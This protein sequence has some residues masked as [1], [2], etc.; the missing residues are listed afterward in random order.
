[1]AQ[2][3]APFGVP[4]GAKGKAKGGI[5]EEDRSRDW[6]CSKCRERNFA[7]RGECFKCRSVKPKD[8]DCTAPPRP[9]VPQSGTTL[10]GMVKSYNKKGFG[11]IMVLGM[12]ECQDIYYTRENLSPRLQTRDIPG[13]H[14]TFEIHR[15][16]DGKLVA[17]NIR[18]IGSDRD[19]T[20]APPVAPVPGKAMGK[21]FGNSFSSFSSISAPM[22]VLSKEEEDRSRDWNCASCGERNFVKRFECFKCKLPRSLNSGGFSSPPPGAT[23]LPPRRSFSPHAGSRAVRDTLA[24]AAA[25]G[26]GSS[27]SR[28]RGRNKKRK[29]K[30]S[31]SSSSRSRRKK[32][33]KGKRRRSRSSSKSSKDSKSS[34]SRSS[35]SCKVEGKSH[36]DAASSGAAAAAALQAQSSGNPDIEQAK[37]EALEQMMKLRSVEPREARM[38]EFRAL[39]R[40]W[41]PDKNPDKVEV[42]TAV[43][44]FLQKGKAMFETK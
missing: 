24:A 42:A 18:P 32:K 22:P 13:E 44:Q 19:F 23:P 25:A 12:E 29:R 34:S 35:S 31:S 2:F 43:F 30:R 16:P 26:S 36:G 37:A 28:R 3:G 9:S 41:H 5:D 15:F 6:Y 40:L 20:V 11:F 10:N 38:T 21:G 27:E 1:M 33:K 14:V 4:F 39:L 8:A 17:R 7:K